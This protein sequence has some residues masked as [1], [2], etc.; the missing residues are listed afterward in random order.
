[1][2]NRPDD[3]EGLGDFRLRI[4]TAWND[5]LNR[6]VGKH[7]LMICHAGV[8]RMAIAYILDIPLSNLFRIK[9]ANAGIT[10]IECLEQG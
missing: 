1:M 6:H 4:V 2:N 5:T 7:I 9:V 10:R 8:V 3:A